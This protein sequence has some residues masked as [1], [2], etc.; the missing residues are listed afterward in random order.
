MI[1]MHPTGPHELEHISTVCDLLAGEVQILPIKIKRDV[2]ILHDQILKGP[3]KLC[4][5][6]IWVNVISQR[7]HPCEGPEID[8]GRA[9]WALWP[10]PY[11]LGISLLIILS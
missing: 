11:K 5:R 8:N 2:K 6:Q 7:G 1:G 3:Q 9:R 4:E 10:K